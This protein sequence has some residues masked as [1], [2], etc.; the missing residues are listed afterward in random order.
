MPPGKLPRH[1]SRRE[2][3]EARIQR[4]QGELVALQNRKE[5]WKVAASSLI[6]HIKYLYQY[7]DPNTITTLRQRIDAL[8]DE[9]DRE[10]HG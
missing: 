3:L 9:I 2:D 10:Y 1:A 6:E 5:R 7:S 4:L 8:Q